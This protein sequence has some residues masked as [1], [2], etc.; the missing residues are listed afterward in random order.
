MRHRRGP[1]AARAAEV[2]R[3]IR[4]PAA[5][6]SLLA[7]FAAVL[8]V[9]LVVHGVTVQAVGSS[10]TPA[11][12]GGG[13]PLAGDRPLLTAHGGRLVSRQPPPRRRV[14]LTF[15]DGPNP[16]WTLRIARELRRLRAPAAFFVTGSEVVRHPDIVRELHRQGF[17][18]GNHTF[19][20]ADI[21]R[22]AGWQRALE[23]EATG[24][25]LA[26]V[27]GTRTRLF[28]PPYSATPAQLSREQARALTS[29]A[30]E[31]Y[32]I[33][34]S[35]FDGRDWERGRTVD[36]IV[37]SA[38]PP[39]AEGGV[40]L[41][42]DG[43]GNRARTLA[44]LPRIVERLRARLPA[45]D[46]LA[47]ARAAAPGDSPGSVA[48]ST[49]TRGTLAHRHERSPARH[50]TRRSVHRSR[51]GRGLVFRPRVRV[52][53]KVQDLAPRAV[54]I[55]HIPLPLRSPAEEPGPDA[56]LFA[57]GS[58]SRTAPALIVALPIGL[59]E[60]KPISSRSGP[61]SDSGN[62]LAPA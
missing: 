55:R 16:T 32:V 17:E 57:P 7:F 31:G 42:H 3:R 10:G 30:R 5:H 36:A 44:A 27:T 50:T 2:R 61:R 11:V 8:A 54:G 18:L 21:A 6:R 38:L 62:R 60:A 51:R 13:S 49:A 24:N 40:V 9:L 15:D 29:I 43:G 46:R 25:A 14:A 35:D 23:V 56:G 39:G 33:A 12:A 53:L 37:R 45:R 1:S 28:R 26:A 19:T 22:R 20:H 47:T 48:P 52:G 58:A 34:L 4:R 41:L 59:P